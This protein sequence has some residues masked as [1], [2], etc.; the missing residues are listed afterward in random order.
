MAN[1][2]AKNPWQPDW[3]DASPMLAPLL[4]PARALANRERWPTLDEYNALLE[5]PIHTTGG[6]P[7]RFA[8]QDSKPSCME[9]G[10]EARIY[11]TG[12]VQTRTGNWHDFFNTLVWL[13]F[14]RT[15]S[16]LNARHFDTL[17]TD[18]ANPNR[19]QS[20]DALTLFDESGVAVVYDDEDLAQLLREHHWKELFWMRRR[21]VQERMKFVVFGHSLHEKA[22]RPY[23]GFT[24]KGLLFK[25]EPSFFSMSPEKQGQ[26]LDN[27]MA[28]HFADG[29]PLSSREFTPIPLLGVPDWWPDN[30]N[31]WFYENTG[32][33]RP[34][35]KIQDNK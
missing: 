34:P 9:D 21:E 20:R 33:F 26:D 28:A 19:G 23:L 3:A 12:E 5:P 2:N 14:P 35:R 15:K 24:G 11:L 7:L 10:Y 27:I 6:A 18:F 16:A 1:P 32:Y 17:S 13:A 31:D 8:P 25:A 29:E 30:E 22:L 4:G